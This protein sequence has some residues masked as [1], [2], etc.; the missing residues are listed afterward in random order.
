M[1]KNRGKPTRN[2]AL[3]T[4]RVPGGLLQRSRLKPIGLEQADR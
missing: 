1:R 4:L 2:I 3:G